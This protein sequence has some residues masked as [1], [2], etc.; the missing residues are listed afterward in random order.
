[1]RQKAYLAQNNFLKRLICMFTIVFVINIFSMYYVS[2]ENGNQS[3]VV[4][5][6]WFT[7]DGVQYTDK[8]G[9][10][11]GYSY[12]YL[13]ELCK[14]SDFSYEYIPASWKDCIDML[15]NGEIDVLPYIQY[16]DER[17]EYFD[18]TTMP[19]AQSYSVLTTRVDNDSIVENNIK[20]FSGKK[21]G[22]IKE[23]VQRKHLEKFLEENSFSAEMVEFEEMEHML[24]ALEEKKIDMTV[25]NNFSA[26]SPQEKV[27]A[28]FA[29]NK[30]YLAVK[31]GNMHL[32][33]KLDSALSYVEMYNPNLSQKLMNKYFYSG[34]KKTALLTE[35]EKQYLK[36]LGKLRFVAT[37]NKGYFSEGNDKSGEGINKSIL[38]LIS[39]NLGIEYEYIEVENYKEIVD[40]VT[41]DDFDVL[42]GFY[43]DY[44]W[45]E[46][47]DVYI[48]SP[49][50]TLQYYEIMNK[51]NKSFEMKDATVAATYSLKFSHE[52][53]REHFDDS[54]ITWYDTEKECI[55]AVRDGNQD[56]AYCDSYTAEYYLNDYRYNNLKVSLIPYKNDV[57]FAT[58]KVHGKKLAAILSKF[59]SSVSSDDINLLVSESTYHPS[60]ESSI[61]EFVY[62][63]PKESMI[64]VTVFIGTVFIIIGLLYLYTINKRKNYE[65][66]RANDAKTQFLSHMSHEIR[67]P[68]NGIKGMLDL[69]KAQPY[70]KENEYIEKALL[71]VKHLTGLINDILDMSKIEQNKIKLKYDVSSKKEFLEYIDAVIRPMADKKK[72]TLIFE[73]YD[74]PYEYIC[75]DFGRL[76]Q[77]MI[78]LLSNAIKYTNPEG[79]V[80]YSVRGELVKST[81]NNMI[82]LIFAVE[83][84]GIGMTEDFLKIATKPFEQEERMEKRIGTGLGLPITKNLI[85]L[86]GGDLHI[87]SVVNKGTKASFSIIV[88]YIENSDLETQ[89]KL[90]NNPEEELKKIDL[91]G[92]KVLI[93]EDNELNMEIAKI[94]LE[95]MGFEIIMAY[96]GEEAV[97][98][99]INSEEG[100]FSAIFMD[101]M[102]PKKS[103]LEA[104]KEIR[105]L[106]R[107]DAKTIPIVAMTANAFADDV[108]KSIES[109]MNYHLSKPFE[110]KEMQQI[111]VSIFKK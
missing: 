87:E 88:K 100:Y 83:D 39:E 15:K 73:E 105:K 45:A 85:E 54:K 6:G 59:L 14:Y 101:I 32:L 72:I 66:R 58:S 110:K 27:V 86:M 55:D 41:A 36:S 75:I 10:K 28:S 3:E 42:C 35:D 48:T 19:V 16:T 29:P 61:E 95:S 40:I 53:V 8:N 78:N 23:T 82:R 44:N 97:T 7:L 111:I 77:I 51:N 79:T 102:M 109:G 34:T 24:A 38:K 93:A 26:I 69:F 49:Y 96:N 103:G 11:K 43:F 64:L 17:A 30:I 67:T 80:I 63:N 57:C 25:N 2:A 60:S 74:I 98:K 84:N 20:T 94:Q 56:I 18:F 12:D 9:N 70:Y 108:H 47:R 90:L 76:K 92:K 22:Y 21:I 5:I 33:E 71:S 62:S 4:K 37:K 106:K 91:L 52:Y 46:K 89:S 107:E 99:F 65:L 81:E 1:M 68:L 13:Q 104:T 50:L 31:K